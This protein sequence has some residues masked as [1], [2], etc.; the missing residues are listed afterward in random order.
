ML[1]QWSLLTL[2]WC[3][4]WIQDL[5]YI[6]HVNLSHFNFIS[7]LIFH[8]HMKTSWHENGFCITGTLWGES[9]VGFP[10]TKGPVMQSLDVSS[11]VG[12][13][14]LLYKQ[15]NCWWYE[16]MMPTGRH[17]DD[18]TSKSSNTADNNFNS[19]CL[20]EKL[21]PSGFLYMPLR[22]CLMCLWDFALCDQIKN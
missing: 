19:I 14:M 2:M 4:L 21:E 18:G 13:N 9:T 8:W 11:V 5:A 10:L 1:I 3:A 7:F 22:N 20:N 12:L 16:A 15:S 17:C 6:F